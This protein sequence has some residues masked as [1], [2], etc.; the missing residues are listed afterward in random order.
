MNG[1]TAPDVSFDEIEETLIR[2][3][4]VGSG[5]QAVVLVPDPPTL[6]STMTL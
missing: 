1:L 6:S 4:D 2:V 5:P 3:R